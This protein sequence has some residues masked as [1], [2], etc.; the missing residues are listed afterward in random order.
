LVWAKDVVDGQAMGQGFD[1]GGVK[2]PELVEI[3][4]DSGKLGGEGG[5]FLVGTVEPSEF[6]DMPD[7]IFGKF[8]THMSV[9]PD[10]WALRY[11]WTVTYYTDKDSDC[12]DGAK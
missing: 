10:I 11:F 3:V 5:D 7:L 2:L 12:E 1:I 4:K 6:G 9:S 8:F